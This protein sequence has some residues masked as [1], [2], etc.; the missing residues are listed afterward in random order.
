MK[1]LIKSLRLLTHQINKKVVDQK[2]LVLML[3]SKNEKKII[4]T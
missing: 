3:H 4:K 2:K 1:I